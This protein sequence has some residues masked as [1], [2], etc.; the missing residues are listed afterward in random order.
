MLKEI[1]SL[2]LDASNVSRVGLQALSD[3]E[4]KNTI[5]KNIFNEITLTLENA[6]KPRGQTELMIVDAVE[7]LVNFIYKFNTN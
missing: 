1:E 3:F 5:D 4:K 2:S 6:K 7:K